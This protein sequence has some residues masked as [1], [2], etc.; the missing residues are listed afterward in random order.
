MNTHQSPVL[1]NAV[2]KENRDK[3]GDLH[4]SILL[5]MDS[6]GLV[7]YN[8]NP[9]TGEKVYLPLSQ[10]SHPIYSEQYTG[11][12]QT[13]QQFKDDCDINAVLKKYGA[14]HDY[15]P[16]D[17]SIPVEY[18]RDLSIAP[19]D[20]TEAMNLVQE[21]NETFMDLPAHLRKAVN[22]DPRRLF[23]LSQSEEGLK[24]LSELGF[25]TPQ[26]AP[27]FD[28]KAVEPRVAPEA[29]AKQGKKPQGA[30]AQN[31]ESDEE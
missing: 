18:F 25:A 7:Y 30:K 13:Q 9:K 8:L 20:L 19:R 2:I 11:P 28:S 17:V 15:V 5:N 31:D 6:S 14:H 16:E 21:A 3:F 10:L 27:N 23:E 24:K 12:S 29:P 22:D 1:K 26:E 4:E